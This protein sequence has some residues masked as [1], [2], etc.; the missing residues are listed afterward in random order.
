MDSMIPDKDEMITALQHVIEEQIVEIENLKK[1]QMTL[2]AARDNM[3][4]CWKR[5]HAEVK[6]LEKTLDNAIMTIEN[7]RNGFN[8]GQ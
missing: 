4:A 2:I 3:E 8:E 1:G 5:E 6:R 7:Y